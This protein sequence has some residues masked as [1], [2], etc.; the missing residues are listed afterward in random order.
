MLLAVGIHLFL[1]AFFVNLYVSYTLKGTEFKKVYNSN[2]GAQNASLF[3][4]DVFEKGANFR[5]FNSLKGLEHVYN[6]IQVLVNLKDNWS[7]PAHQTS[8]SLSNLF[9]FS[10]LSPPGLFP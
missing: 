5:S 2:P 7:S 3:D 6:E 1:V 4:S 8:A 10:D 9:N